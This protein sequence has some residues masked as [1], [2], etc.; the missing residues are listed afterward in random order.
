MVPDATKNL[1]TSF[2]LLGPVSVHSDEGALRLG[3]PRQVAVLARLMLGPR[4][5]VTMDQL[6]ESVW[7]GNTPARPEVAIRSYVSNLR[8]ILEPDRSTRTD[9]SVLEGTP[10]GY[11]LN[12]D[13]HNFDWIRFESTIRGSKRLLAASSYNEAA[14]SVRDVLSLWHGDPCSGIADSGVIESHRVRLR[15]LR[16]IGIESLFEAQL[17]LGEHHSVAA[18][19]ES[20][21]EDHPF[22]ERLTELGMVALYRCSRQAEALDLGNRLR[23]RLIESMGVDPSP[24]VARL[25]VQILNHD[26]ALELHQER[27]RSNGIALS[28]RS[29][30]REIRLES[31]KVVEASPR[32]RHFTPRLGPLSLPLGQRSDLLVGRDSELHIAS[33]FA[34]AIAG[35]MKGNLI[36]TGEAGIGKS[37]LVKALGK[38]LDG[39]T[40]VHSARCIEAASGMALWPWLQQLE[41]LEMPGSSE[42]DC[43]T[44]ATEIDNAMLQ[45]QPTQC[46]PK[47]RNSLFERDTPLLLIFE[48]V[49]WAD[50]ESLSLLEFCAR[51]QANNLVSFV[52]TWNENS[53]V[54]QQ[55]RSGLRR[56]ARLPDL[57]RL[58]LG[59][60]SERAAAKLAGAHAISVGENDAR[61]LQKRT[62]GNPL[63]LEL[64]L[65]SK[66]SD[67]QGAA[68][69]LPTSLRDVILDRV[70]AAGSEIPG[71]LSEAALVGTTFRLDQMTGGRS[72]IELV[73][74]ASAASAAG[75]VIENAQAPGSYRFVHDVV[76][77]VLLAQ[78]SGMERSLDVTAEYPASLIKTLG[79][80]DD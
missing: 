30:G 25:E 79:N 53:E 3:G 22:R 18:S 33:E 17:G 75:L 77:E 34:N 72:A 2:R 60:L 29:A 52:L 59:P 51:E 20:V 63:Y 42:S 35:G 57:T 56:L 66:V 16:Q 13:D 12:V 55:N 43:T 7:D 14:R 62:G 80:V 54:Y 27:H 46:F 23:Q 28:N 41:Q 69:P 37:T 38:K 68:W 74:T 19:I 48:D 31:K 61:I 32:K 1:P 11:R 21:I 40:E 6:V 73:R 71:F 45:Q 76:A 36:V 58:E 5:V 24:S 39:V 15:E 78:L 65:S 10:P 47:I 50:A 8:R 67:I 26:D 9:E 49:E 44:L 70:E 4:Q 64:L